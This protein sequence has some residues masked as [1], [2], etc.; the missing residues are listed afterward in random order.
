M[1]DA[2]P[3]ACTCCCCCAAP[4]VVRGLRSG[5]NETGFATA[6]T[7]SCS[8]SREIG[9]PCVGSAFPKT[10]AHT[11]AQKHWAARQYPPSA[12]GQLLSVENLH[13]CTCMDP[14]WRCLWLWKALRTMTNCLQL[15]PVLGRT[16]REHPWAFVVNLT[17]HR[18]KPVSKGG[19][20]RRQ[21][22]R[23]MC[24]HDRDRR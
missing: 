5:K 12:S 14:M 6:K 4:S 24:S 19:Q 10:S 3:I 2:D 11:H 20:Q 17:V 7:F 13:A 18:T 8:W 15:S 16:S 22:G 9:A 21:D 1:V 23:V